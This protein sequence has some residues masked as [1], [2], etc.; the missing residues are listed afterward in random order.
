MANDKLRDRSKDLSTEVVCFCSEL[1]KRKVD[2]ST[3]RQIWK[4]GTSVFANVNEAH[5][6]QGRNDFAAKLQIALKECRECDGWFEMLY[7]S[8]YISKSEYK[9]F[10][11]RCFEISRLLSSSIRTARENE[12]KERERRKR[13]GKVQ[14]ESKAQNEK[15]Q[16]SMEE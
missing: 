16:N 11:N 12:D 14:E 13:K 6:A 1:R 7:A 2:Q 15:L 5:A 8:G 9:A 4:A 3:V 10:H